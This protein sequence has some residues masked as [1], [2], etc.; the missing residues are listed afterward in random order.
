MA[1]L[2]K[3]LNQEQRRSLRSQHI[4]AKLTPAE[5]RSLNHSASV[6]KSGSIRSADSQSIR[7]LASST[8]PLTPEYLS[9]QQSQ[10]IQTPRRSSR[11]LPTPPISPDRERQGSNSGS[12]H[13]YA[14]KPI[15]HAQAV[16]LAN[17]HSHARPPSA[18]SYRGVATYRASEITRTSSLT[19]SS[20]QIVSNPLSQF[21]RPRQ[22]TLTSSPQRAG[23]E[24]RGGEDSVVSP[25][26]MQQR[27]QS[28]GSTNHAP[29]RD[30]S[31][32]RPSDSPVSI[33]G[34]KT[35]ELVNA[36]RSGNEQVPIVHV[37][38]S[39]K[40]DERYN[41]ASEPPKKQKSNWRRTFTG[42]TD[43]EPEV[44]QLRK[45]HRRRTLMH[46]GQGS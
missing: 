41:A 23:S 15:S 21:S 6:S 35:P 38:P 44:A 33:E 32:I 1:K 4:V 12:P 19:T 31:P 17:A 3:S 28:L 34:G 7:R 37:T 42:G 29:S 9:S 39:V 18:T 26:A 10:V 2:K 30:H 5:I 24:Q 11:E 22:S 13:I 27:H 14:P 36:D 20:Q 8:P 45:E 16:H 25:V 46:P 43:S 40:P